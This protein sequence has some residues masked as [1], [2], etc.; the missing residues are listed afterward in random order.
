MAFG[1]EKLTRLVQQMA[2]QLD[3]VHTELRQ[4][5]DNARFDALEKQLMATQQ[6]LDASLDAL[7]TA[8]DTGIQQILAAVQD[9]AGRVGPG[10]DL[11]AEVARVQKAASDIANA[12]SQVQGL[13]VA[14]VPPTPPTP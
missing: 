1:I 2:A 10:V 12:A 9:I 14:P 7:G 13:D 5:P 4:L 8:M 3:A 11:S 6:D